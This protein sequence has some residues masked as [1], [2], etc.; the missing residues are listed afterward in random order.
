[1][2]SW[3]STQGGNGVRV[4]RASPLL[5]V[6]WDCLAGGSGAADLP[7]TTGQGEHLRTLLAV[8]G[9]GSYPRIP[10]PVGTPH[11][12]RAASIFQV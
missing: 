5:R 3:W 10:T 8:L 2:A 9:R 11:S 6:D 7:L 12:Q 4:L 1:M